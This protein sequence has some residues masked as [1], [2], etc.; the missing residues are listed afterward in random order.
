MILRDVL[1][2][3]VTVDPGDTTTAQYTL[4]TNVAT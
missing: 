4:R 3:V 2:G 1:A